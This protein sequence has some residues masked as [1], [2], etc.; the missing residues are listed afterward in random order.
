MGENLIILLVTRILKQ[1]DC[2][3]HLNIRAR[4]SS[5]SLLLDKKVLVQQLTNSLLGYFPFKEVQAAIIILFSAKALSKDFLIRYF[6]LPIHEPS[7][8][9]VG[10]IK[11]PPPRY[12]ES[13]WNRGRTFVDPVYF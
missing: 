10:M 4:R 7:T 12:M 5:A 1:Q 11:A 3:A 2:T 6:Q 13:F 8:V 9:G